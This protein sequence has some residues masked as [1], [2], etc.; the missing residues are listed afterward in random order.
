MRTRFTVT[1]GFTDENVRHQL[2]RGGCSDPFY[3][4]GPYKSYTGSET[5]KVIQDVVTPGF[6]SLLKC[7]GFLPLN[8]MTISTVKITRVASDG[9]YRQANGDPM[10]C[11]VK[12]DDGPLWVGRSWT[13]GA[14]PPS[15]LILQ[16]LYN[17]SAANAVS[18]TFDALTFAAELRQTSAMLQNSFERV[19]KFADK[20]AKRVKKLERNPWRPSPV[21]GWSTDTAG[22]R[23]SI[24]M[25]M[26]SK[27]YPNL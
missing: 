24:H 8:P 22:C 2:Q 4:V 18:A 9:P 20:A 12:M 23:S 16:D 13:T 7:G 17:R 6:T 26:R 3:E 11:Y 25:M 27:P 1:G 19:A 21:T 10:T 15:P 5:T 14:P